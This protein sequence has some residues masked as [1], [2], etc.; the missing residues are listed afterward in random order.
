MHICFCFYPSSLSSLVSVNF[1]DLSLSCPARSEFKVLIRL[2]LSFYICFKD[3][4]KLQQDALRAL[5][6]LL[7][8][9]TNPSL[10]DHHFR[11]RDHMPLHPVAPLGATPLSGVWKGLFLPPQLI[12]HSSKPQ[13]QCRHL[14]GFYLLLRCPALGVEH[15]VFTVATWTRCMSLRSL[16]LHCPKRTYFCSPAPSAAAP[17][18]FQIDIQRL[19]PRWSPNSTQPHRVRSAR[20]N[21]YHFPMR[22]QF[23]RRKPALRH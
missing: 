5:Q 2:Q 9:Q 13:L 4:S 7:I 21:V 14:K 3:Y 11:C 6:W 18:S 8:D 19:R 22:K 15:R 12:K 23:S 1:E 16:G 20:L 10:T 17:L